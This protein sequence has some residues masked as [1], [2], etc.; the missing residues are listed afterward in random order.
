MNGQ[1]VRKANI[2]ICRKQMLQQTVTISTYYHSSCLPSTK[3]FHFYLRS[4]PATSSS[5]FLGLGLGPYLGSR[6]R[7]TLRVI[8]AWAHKF[9]I[10]ACYVPER[11]EHKFWPGNTMRVG[12]PPEQHYSQCRQT[13]KQ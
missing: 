4:A 3:V 8:W 9:K 6:S 1:N 11:D 10:T 13:K 12:V 2:V 7:F 5:R